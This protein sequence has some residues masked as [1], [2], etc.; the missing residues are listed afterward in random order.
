MRAA[1]TAE[2]APVTIPMPCV[3]L[4]TDRRLAGG[5]DALMTAVEA[6]LAGGVSIVQMRE[7]DLPDAEQLVLA[8]RLRELT[9]GR[10]LLFVNDS[11]AVAQAAGADGVQLA[12]ASR[13]VAS[14]LDAMGGRRL[15]VGRSVH[16]LAGATEAAEQGADLLVAGA[17][18]ETATHPGQAAAGTGLV[19]QITRAVRLPVLGIGGITAANAPSVIAAGAAGVAVV[20]SVLAA[21]DPNAA[22]R[23]LCDAAAHAW[24]ARRA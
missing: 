16:D 7:K 3:A 21:G 15:L 23:A 20:T 11:V 17:V 2:A 12:E 10:A 24:A 4:V 6:A 13:T 18:F 9:F 14:A 19:E 8:R 22:A 5:V 1:R